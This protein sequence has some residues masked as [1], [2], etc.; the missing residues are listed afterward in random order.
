MRY[1]RNILQ[2]EFRDCRTR[3]VYDPVV[4]STVRSDKM[5][6]ELRLR[7]DP[8]EAIQALYEAHAD[9]ISSFLKARFG[10]GP[11]DPQDIV[12]QTFANFLG[13]GDVPAIRNPRAFLYRIAINLTIQQR[14]AA[15]RRRKLLP[16]YARTHGDPT[17]ELHPERVLLAKE[18]VRAL[19]DAL[20]QLA[21]RDRTLLLLHRLEGVSY[22]EIARRTG[23]AAS[24]VRYV[25]GQALK[26]CQQ[27]LQSSGLWDS[28]EG[29]DDAKP[30]RQ[31]RKSG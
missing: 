18:Q 17:D 3:P 19:E 8:S 30:A 29:L 2:G 25:I 1:L 10:A 26:N 7:A 4:L 31:R 12:Q 14:R 28:S 23:M 22:A 13:Q 11:P 20:N 27:A 16:E 6:S 24:S 15:Q 5:A 9:E 21:E